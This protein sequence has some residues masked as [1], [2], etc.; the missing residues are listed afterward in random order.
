[1]TTT[2]AELVADARSRVEDLDVDTVAREVADGA[3]VVDLREEAER[4]T[5]GA[6][7]GAVHVP[8]GLLEFQ[9]DRSA[10]THKGDLDPRRRTILY[11][12][13][14]G[15]SA[16]AAMSLVALGY[17]NVAHLGAG[18]QAWL[19]AGRPTEMVD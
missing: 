11:C 5:S 8:R 9:A 7:P 2:A 16:L 1:M 10:A 19:D 4:Q 6:I 15:R 17:E 12:A 14:G 18:F 13:V 3:L